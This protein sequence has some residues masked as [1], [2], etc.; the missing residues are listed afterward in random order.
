MDQ[1][2]VLIIS[3]E[4]EFSHAITSRWQL[5]H[6]VPSFTLMSGDLCPGLN[7]EGF[8]AAI[9]GGLPAAEWPPIVRALENCGKAVLLVGKPDTLTLPA[10]SAKSR[11]LALERDGQWLD[12]IVLILTESLTVAQFAGRTQQLEKKNALLARDAALGRYILEMRHSLN[13]ALTSV[14]GNSELLLLEPETLAPLDPGIRSQIDTIRNMAL[15]MHEIL[16]RFSSLEKELNVAEK[17][18]AKEVKARAH[19]ASTTA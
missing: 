4:A 16:Q 1:P 9:V 15:R 19:A 2:T 6:S 10:S 18:A 8:D 14:L 3:N 11:L 7:S 17:Q 12:A 13:N 5:E